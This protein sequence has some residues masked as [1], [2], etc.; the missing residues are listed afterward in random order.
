MWYQI[1]VITLRKIGIIGK[2]LIIQIDQDR[3]VVAAGVARTE[4]V[5]L[6]TFNVAGEFVGCSLAGDSDGDLGCTAPLLRNVDNTKIPYGQTMVDFEITFFNTAGVPL[7]S[8]CNGIL[9][10]RI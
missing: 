10:L 2:L 9:Y 7:S 8:N 5:T 6:S 4:T 1:L 3:A